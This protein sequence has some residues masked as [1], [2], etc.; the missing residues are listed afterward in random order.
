MNNEKLHNYHLFTLM[1]MIQSGI[2]LL[3][4]PRLLA[5]TYGTNGWVMLILPSAVS[6]LVIYMIALIYK[7]GKG[8]SLFEL[9]ER[10][11]SKYLL[12]PIYTFFVIVWSMIGILIS[13]EYVLLVQ[14]YNF[15]TVPEDYLLI[16]MMLVV[17]FML[18][19]KIHNMAKA[20]VIFFLLSVWMIFLSLYVIPHFSFARLTPYFMQLGS[21][22]FSGQL[23]VLGAFLGFEIFL[24]LFPYVDRQA[25]FAQSL[26]YGNLFTTGIYMIVS[27]TNFGFFCFEQLKI[28]YYPVISMLQYIRAPFVERLE[29]LLIGVFF[30]KMLVT[31]CMYYWI[32]LETFGRLTPRVSYLWR[33]IIVLF[34]SYLVSTMIDGEQAT[35]HWL[36]QLFT[37]ESAAACLVP[38]ILL[39]LIV[40]FRRNLS[41]EQP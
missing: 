10:R 26:Q 34:A 20:T 21:F 2:T 18:S 7:H 31:V 36:Q 14:L 22:D 16:V 11:L 13:K 24:F 4:L 41:H 29:T 27:F 40:L 5:E 23:S 1:Y 25:K 37:L 28:D 3:S 19:K 12:Y 6:A 35:K 33:I 15:P 8:L 39:L 30:L 17:C 9:M 32:A 38:C